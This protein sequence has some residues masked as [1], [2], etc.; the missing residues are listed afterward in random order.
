MKKIVIVLFLILL[1]TMGL[2]SFK[3]RYLSDPTFYWSVYRCEQFIT[4]I[5]VNGIFYETTVIMKVKL[6]RGPHWYQSY[7]VEDPPQGK[8]EFIWVFRLPTECIITDC[9]VWDPKAGKYLSAQAID[10]SAGEMQYNPNSSDVPQLLL[11]QYRGRQYSGYWDQFYQLNLAPVNHDEVKEIVL[12]FLAPCRMYWAKR[13]LVIDT[14]QLYQPGNWNYDYDRKPAQFRVYDYNN[15][16]TPPENIYNISVAW[17]KQAGFWYATTGP[18]DIRF[19]NQCVVAV[20]KESPDGKFLQ[21]YSDS[22]HQFYQLATLPHVENA[23]IPPRRIIIGFDLVD[24]PYQSAGFR[25]NIIEQIY[26]TILYATTPFDSLMFVTSSFTV[27]WLDT[28]FVAQSPNFIRSRLNQVKSIIPKLNTLPFMLR[29]AVQFL[30][31]RDVS[32]EIWVVSNAKEH[33]NPP[34]TAMDIVNQT[35]FKAK[36]P[37]RFRFVDAAFSYLP[38]LVINNVSYKGNEYLYEVLV[39]LSKGTMCIL[40]NADSYN[41]GNNLMDCLTPVVSSVEIDPR[42]Y[43]GL[44]FSRIPIN[45]GRTN[46]NITSRYFEIGLFTGDAPFQIDYYGNLNEALYSKKFSFET[47]NQGYSD[48]LRSKVK[49]F[50]YAQY[51]NELLQQPQ[52]YATIKYIEQITVEN[53]ILSPYTGFILPGTGGYAGFK[54]LTPEDTLQVMQQPHEQHPSP[55]I[56]DD[57]QLSAYPNPFNPRTTI[58]IR[59]PLSGDSREARLVILNMLGQRIKTY[60]LPIEAVAQAMQVEWDGRDDAGTPVGSGLYFVRLMVGDVVKSI[61]ISLV[62]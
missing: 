50:W 1:P 46:F 45:W 61:K 14:R 38:Y 41:W 29:E 47:N 58:Q 15:P 24:E 13:R 8:Y 9:Q 28:R 54:S 6:A 23:D 4:E 27:N 52:S 34:Q 48:E 62:R 44:S 19:G 35:Y 21:T 2:T 40:R 42:P 60:S 43:Q 22:V 53:H 55:N 11:R 51:V 17:Q 3:A 25:Q 16:D 36:H 39:R 7:Y 59:L 20:A 18:D 30:N 10:R 26:E 57:Y 56:P 32:G 5:R 33:S 12:K 37:I 49:L 31:D